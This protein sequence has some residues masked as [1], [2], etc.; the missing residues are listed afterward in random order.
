MKRA[1]VV[2]FRLLVHIDLEQIYC[3]CARTLI[4]TLKV[5]FAVYYYILLGLY[6]KYVPLNSGF[7]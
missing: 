6:E 1:E 5:H 4:F 2:Q 7:S 3:Q